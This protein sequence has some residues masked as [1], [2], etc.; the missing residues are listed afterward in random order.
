MI[1]TYINN[2]QYY[3]LDATDPYTKLG[4][5]S[6][7]I[8]GREALVNK[9][10]REYE[11]IDVPV[12]PSDLNMI[13]DSVFVRFDGDVLIG[14]GRASF[15]GY[16]RIGVTHQLMNSSVEDH[17]KLFSAILNKGSNKFRLEE[18]ETINLEEKNKELE[19]NYSFILPDYLIQ[20]GDDIYLNPH[21][22]KEFERELID[23]ESAGNDQFHPYRWT[24]Y[25]KIS[26]EIPQD[27]TVTYLPTNLKY[28]ND[29][30]GFTL[31]YQVGKNQLI[32]EQKTYLN[33]RTVKADQFEIW[34]E[35]VRTLLKA[36]KE[37]V[38]F[39]K[40]K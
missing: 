20:S 15:T 17:D 28:G 11:L 27:H 31:S 3:F 2:G 32:M 22:A 21:L 26:I 14:R 34:N 40:I 7:H 5:P 13:S 25:N 4:M 1:C 16:S 6:H 38:V 9:G 12:I 36:Y 39:S 8:Q 30:F 19:V 35:M 24:N 23:I 33:V 10:K 29:S 18:F 37:T